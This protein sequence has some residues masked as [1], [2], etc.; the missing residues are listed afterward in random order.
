MTYG[1]HNLHPT[2]VMFLLVGLASKIDSV[3]GRPCSSSG[4]HCAGFALASN[5]LMKYQTSVATARDDALDVLD[6]AD[7]AVADGASSGAVMSES[8]S[9]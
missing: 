1:P 7:G 8:R 2:C 6:G 5:G 4:G 9:C 3:T